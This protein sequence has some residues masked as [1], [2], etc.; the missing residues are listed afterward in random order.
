MGPAPDCAP[1]L[2]YLANQK[3]STLL[4]NEKK[5]TEYALLNDK[6]PCLTVLFDEVSP[7]TVGQ[8]ILFFEAAKSRHSCWRR[9]AARFRSIRRTPIL[10]IGVR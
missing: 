4:N 2:S 9:A 10:C 6:R 8:F 5:A 1:E 7:Y 3:M